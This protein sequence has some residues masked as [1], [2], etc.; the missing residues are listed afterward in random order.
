M[1]PTNCALESPLT[2]SSCP[3]LISPEL[4]LI[5]TNSVYSLCTILLLNSPIITAII[6]SIN[7]M[8]ESPI[9]AK[10]WGD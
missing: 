5:P 1:L 7:A 8:N 9:R 10:N 3:L 4:I 2:S 6:R